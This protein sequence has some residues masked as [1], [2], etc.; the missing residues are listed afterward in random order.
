[1][2]PG[3]YANNIYAV[4]VWLPEAKMKRIIG[5]DIGATSIRVALGDERGNV[6]SRLKERTDE[7][8][9]PEGISRQ[10]VRMIHSLTSLTKVR[11]VG[12]GAAGPLDLKEGAIVHSPNIGFDYIPLV[13]P[14]VKE[15]KVP[16]YLA[17]D[18]VAG[19][20]G[21][22]EFGQGRGCANL[23]YVTIS[24][25]IGGGVFV[26]NHLLLGKDGNAHEI[27]HLT[28]DHEGKLRCGCGKKG[29]WEAYCGGA[30][31]PNFI[32]LQL[33][34][35][36]RRE[37][38]SSLLGKIARGDLDTLSSKA[39]FTAA[40][41]GDKIALEVVGEMGRLNGVG[42]A[43]VTSAYDP[44]LITVGG[45]ITLANPRLVLNPIRESIDRYSINRVPKIRI[46]KLGEDSVLYGTLA[47]SKYVK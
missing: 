23:V 8:S 17:N 5:V 24:S 4:T 12:I 10:I 31:A 6:F 37:I 7:S 46:T 36:T 41:R 39:L 3:R 18:C 29:H 34:T 35:K 30:N 20:V 28:I 1:M 21:E 2:P 40:K 45:A 38:E 15:L 25:G 14:L 9:G 42:F 32:R 19:V 44:E 22:K 13:K 26:D 33:E 43:N 27:G 16:V 47:L 11:H